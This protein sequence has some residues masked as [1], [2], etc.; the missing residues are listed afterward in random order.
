MQDGEPRVYADTTNQDLGRKINNRINLRMGPQQ[1]RKMWLVCECT[2]SDCEEV[3]QVTADQYRQ[4][5]KGDSYFLVVVG[6]ES[7]GDHI[8][9]R[10][11]SWLTVQ[12]SGEGKRDAEKMDTP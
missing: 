6:H 2:N 9:A 10:D 5:R 11:G 4:I 12:K 3:I 1:T 7:P 8:V